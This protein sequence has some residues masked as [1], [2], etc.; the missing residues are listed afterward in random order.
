[1]RRSRP[2]G[3]FIKRRSEMADAGATDR[4]QGL[5]WAGDC[6]RHDVGERPP[7]N[8][9]AP[10]KPP[11]APFRRNRLTSASLDPFGCPVGSDAPRP[12][13]A[14][15][16]ER[17]NR[18]ASLR[19]LAALVCTVSRRSRRSWNDGDDNAT[20]LRGRYR[21]RLAILRSSVNR[22]FAHTAAA[23]DI[24]LGVLASRLLRLATADDDSC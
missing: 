6:V 1:M 10:P 17:R 23:T 2:S 18:F 4:D 12:V 24:F 16:S 3:D 19:T 20:R 15:R 14:H 5:L 22:R 21:S 9:S 8:S 13:S 7:S 11:T